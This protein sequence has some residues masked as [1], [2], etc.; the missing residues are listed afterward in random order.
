MQYINFG[1]ELF[2]AYQSMIAGLLGYF[3]NMLTENL[4]ILINNVVG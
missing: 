1:L 2:G 3:T 4:G